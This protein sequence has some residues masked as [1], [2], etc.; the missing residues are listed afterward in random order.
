MNNIMH[1]AV[2]AIVNDDSQQILLSKRADHLHQGGLWEFPGGKVEAG[3]SVEQALRR[4]LNE[5]LGL[6]PT[7]S[8]PLIRIY[9]DY[10]DRT[11]LLDVWRVTAFEGEP[12][13]RE[14]QPI[15]WVALADLSTLTFPAANV[16]ILAALSLPD[17]YLIT[18]DFS[19]DAEA[20]L[21]DL[22]VSLK[23]GIR[24]LQLRVKDLTDADFIGRVVAMVHQYHGKILI[25]GSVEQALVLGAD[26][27]HLN[28]QRLDA[29]TARPAPAPFLVAASCH[30]LRQLA[31]AVEMGCNFA[32]LSPVAAT[33]SHPEA[34]PLG[35]SQFKEW[36]DNTALPVFALGGMSVSNLDQ[37]FKHGA[38][39]IAAISGLWGNQIQR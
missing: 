5:E 39:G 14:G 6:R 11:V 21:L 8:R 36:S 4:E 29:C 24:L 38:Q 16:P 9:H 20:F 27:V 33:S 35:W 2:A 32:L 10:P 25:N 17:K 13:G 1:V 12:E 18:P 19:G 31:K 28:S 37:S 15:E 34:K 30:D 22:E 7:A 23:A 3:E 26:G